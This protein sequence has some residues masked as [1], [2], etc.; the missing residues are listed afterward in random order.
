MRRCAKYFSTPRAKNCYATHVPVL[1]GIARIREVRNVLEFG[2]G[3]YS[4]LTF[5][6]AAVFPHLERLESVENDAAWAETINEI[7]KNDPRWT[8]NLVEGEISESVSTFDFEAFDLILIDDSETSDQR[9]RTIR[10]F[11]KRPPHRPWI[12]IHDFEVEDYRRAASGFRQTHRFKAYNPNT[13]LLWSN[14]THAR[15]AKAIDRI[16][17]ANAK[18]LEPDDIPRW[19]EAFAGFR[20]E[21]KL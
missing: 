17:K 4:T 1:I 18:T 10:E 13:G 8:L 20:S 14:T 9:V 16:I 12:V 19:Q 2:C 11:A 6:N 5:L 21:F 15:R 7:G 3:Y